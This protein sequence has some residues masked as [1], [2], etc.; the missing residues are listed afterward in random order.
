MTITRV[1]RA[2]LEAVP[3]MS[4][5]AIWLCVLPPLL[6]RIGTFAVIPLAVLALS[7]AAGRHE[8]LSAYFAGG[9]TPTPDE[10][11]LLAPALTLMCRAQHGPPIVTLLVRR[12]DRNLT[13]DTSGRRT[14]I[15]P[16]GLLNALAR[17]TISPPE[18]AATLI[19]G[20]A[21]V[22]SGH[23]RPRLL[24]AVVRAPWDLLAGGAAATVRALP[25][26]PLICG[27]WHLRALPGGLAVTNSALTGHPV[28][29]V[30]TAVIVGLSY[31][32]TWARS[33]PSRPQPTPGDQALATL[34]LS[35]AHERLIAESRAL[36]DGRSPAVPRL[37]VLG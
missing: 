21:T 12:G 7:V 11:T 9:R 34:G 31:G 22:L 30:V 14:V 4:G 1:R 20:A 15:A 25:G 10:Q 2:L 5:A 27:M 26:G 3:L 18:A 23:T 16:G 35:D 13:A 6:A 24:R 17:G 19:H 33:T 8:R 37:S 32:W 36:N 28:M 29:A